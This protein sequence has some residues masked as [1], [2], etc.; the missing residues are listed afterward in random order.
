MVT[1]HVGKRIALFERLY[2]TKSR[3]SSNNHPGPAFPGPSPYLFYSYSTGTKVAGHSAGGKT[4][5]TGSGH[6]SDCLKE[7]LAG[8]SID[9]GSAK[10]CES[11]ESLFY[12]DEPMHASRLRFALYLARR[13][14][15]RAAALT[16]LFAAAQNEWPKHKGS[17]MQLPFVSLRSLCISFDC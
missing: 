12:S 14:V 7:F 1:A 5:Q 13:Y 16:A 10:C 3:S 6:G 15:A 17:V 4:V 8:N 11:R 2:A 9:K